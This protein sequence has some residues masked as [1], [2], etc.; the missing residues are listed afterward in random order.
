MNRIFYLL[1]SFAVSY[2]V[3]KL[4]IPV[5]RKN[6]FHDVPNERSMHKKIVPRGGGLGIVAAIVVCA[7]V[8]HLAGLPSIPLPL[9]SGAVLIAFT[10]LAD[11]K[12]NLK[13]SIRLLLH[14]LA[15]GIVLWYTGPVLRFPLPAPMDLPLGIWDYFASYIWFMAVMNIYNFLDGIDGFSGLQAVIA[16]VAVA[17]LYQTEVAF[18]FGMS[19]A[20]A[21]AA[22]LLFNWRPA[23]V[24][25]GDVGS[26]TLGFLFAG[27]PFFKEGFATEDGIFHMAMFLFFFLS[28][29]VFT[30]IRRALNKE[31]IWLPHRSHLFQR[32]ATV[33][34]RH[35]KVAAGIMAAAA[36]FSAFHIYNT[37]LL[38]ASPWLSPAVGILLFLL[39]LGFVIF[40]E[41][42]SRAGK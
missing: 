33:Y 10:S 28:D 17:V 32:L 29:G 41:K 30:I 13:V 11:D 22:F 24:F 31:K 38:K 1:C 16:G 42:K 8:A 25:M 40:S 14:T 21:S 23:K 7:L 12:W 26:V 35:D 18:A 34:S 36:A 15:V 39:Y 2:A 37:L 27:F 20:G 6:K 5:L 19:I 4:L 9:L 3:L